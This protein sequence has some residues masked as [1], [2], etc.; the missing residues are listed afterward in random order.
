MKEFREQPLVGLGISLLAFLSSCKGPEAPSRQTI[1]AYFKK[2]PESMMIDAEK[3]AKYKK[4]HQAF[5]GAAGGGKIPD[6][7][8]IRD[9]R[10]KSYEDDP[11]YKGFANV[12]RA[13][14]V[15]D[16]TILVLQIDPVNEKNKKE[17]GSVGITAH[18]RKYIVHDDGSIDVR[19]GNNLARTSGDEDPNFGLA[20]SIDGVTGGVVFYTKN[21]FGPDNSFRLNKEGVM[22]VSDGYEK[23]DATT[24]F[25]VVEHDMERIESAL[26]R[27]ENK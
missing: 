19:M 2:H 12:Y 10:E 18:E 6:K 20:T 1:D 9:D 15:N 27:V 24:A 16:S 25:D 3:L 14:Y 8:D 23:N 13:E 11:E 26:S 5:S 21:D 22:E 4:T 7:L 17:S